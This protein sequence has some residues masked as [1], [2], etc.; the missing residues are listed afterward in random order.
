[1]TR[2]LQLA[3]Q[4]REF[5]VFSSS[6]G[7]YRTTTGP[8]GTWT[9]TAS[10]PT[11]S[12]GGACSSDGYLYAVNGTTTV[13]VYSGSAWSSATVASAA[14]A[15]AP[16]PGT[17]GRAV[18]INQ[19]YGW[20]GVT[21]NHG[22]SWSTQ[23]STA[24]YTTGSASVAWIPW[25]STINQGT[26]FTHDASVIAFNPAGSNELWCSMGIGVL[27]CNPSNTPASSAPTWTDSSAGIENTVVDKIICP[28]G[29]GPI[30]AQWDRPF[31]R[32]L[33]P[34]SFAAFYAPY[35]GRSGSSGNLT[36]GFSVDWV[37]GASNIIVGIANYSID[38][39]GYATDGLAASSSWTI[40][41]SATPSGSNSHNAGSIVA[42]GTSDIAWVGSGSSAT[43]YNTTGGGASW[44][45]ATGAPVATY[46]PNY[47]DRPGNVLTQ[48]RVT[49]A[50]FY[51]TT[52]GGSIYKSTDAGQNWTAG[53]ASLGA[54]SWPQLYSVPGQGGHLFYSN[55]WA[56]T[57]GTAFKFS[58]DGGTTWNT[59][60]SL[61]SVWAYGFGAKY[62][63]QSYPTI[64]AQG[65][66]S[67]VWGTYRC[68]NFNPATF[69]GTWVKIATSPGNNPDEITS[70]CGDPDVFGWVYAGFVGSGGM[71]LV[72]NDAA[73]WVKCSSPNPGATVTRSA[74]VAMTAL[75]ASEIAY[76]S[77]SWVVSDGT[78][79]ATGTGLTPTLNLTGLSAG[80]GT[81]AITA[82][83]NGQS[84]VSTIPITLA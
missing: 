14:W 55:G 67:S 35:N 61:T 28:P 43:L 29:S 26:A 17:T 15:V 11:N 4:R 60:P 6:H 34:D 22:G 38:R 57:S 18:V 20:M 21:L 13:S 65:Y 62:P 64:Y 47:Y 59:V 19:P 33:S 53:A 72:C 56:Q 76:S 48:D 1:M 66:L 41:S 37:T 69:S 40:F 23:N 82:T 8:T 27:V 81:V 12:T 54:T 46:V 3:A 68:I 49:A 7:W 78:N 75:A 73:P 71:T 2:P 30:T 42:S 5:Y 16:D 25:I 36:Q 74:A 79:T 80:A 77:A 52:D 32:I 45:A 10:S 24:S 50:I 83:G 58:S 51:A 84:A 63:G 44:S 39:S 9:L 31:M 70:L